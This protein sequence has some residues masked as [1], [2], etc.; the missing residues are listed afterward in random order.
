MIG[1]NETILATLKR[2]GEQPP[3]ATFDPGWRGHRTSRPI[4]A[5]AIRR[6]L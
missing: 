5:H 4:M 1:Q 2:E 3:V 6:M